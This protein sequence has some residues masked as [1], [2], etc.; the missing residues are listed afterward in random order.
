MTKMLYNIFMKIN[1]TLIEQLKTLALT[2]TYPKAFIASA[3]VHRNKVISFGLNQMKSH[4][5]QKRYGR[6]KDAIYM[7]S[8]VSAIHTAEKKLG[9]DKFHNSTLYVVRVKWTSSNKTS[10]T[11]GMALPC[12]GCM[13][14]I[15]DHGIKTVIYTLD[16]ID[17]EKENFGVLL[18]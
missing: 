16:Q 5:Y 17:N 1:T 12:T 4:P 14:C 2:G 3:L 9:F 6:N 11:S 13:R 18:L 7:H 10:L 15:K 8:E